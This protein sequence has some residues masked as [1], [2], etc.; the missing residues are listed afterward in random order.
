MENIFFIFIFKQMKYQMSTLIYLKALKNNE[1][2]K[3]LSFVQPKLSFL[4]SK[5]NEIK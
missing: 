2:D 3:R 1:K 5:I 4:S